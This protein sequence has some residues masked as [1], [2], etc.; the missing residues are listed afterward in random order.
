MSRAQA[1]HHLW[2]FWVLV[3]ALVLAGS[4]LLGL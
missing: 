3:A 1:S 4:A 2:W